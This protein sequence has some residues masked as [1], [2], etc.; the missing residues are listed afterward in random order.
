MVKCG[1]LFE[2]RP[3]ILK[4]TQTILGLKDLILCRTANTIKSL[5]LKITRA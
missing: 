3:E 1:V 2:V 5:E 4:V